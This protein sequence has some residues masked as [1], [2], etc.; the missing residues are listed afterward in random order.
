[1]NDSNMNSEVS[2]LHTEND[3]AE[4]EQATE[5]LQNESIVSEL[6]NVDD[7][8][9]TY[10]INESNSP[11][12]LKFELESLAIEKARLLKEHEKLNEMLKSI[13]LEEDIAL[14]KGEVSFLAEENDKILLEIQRRKQSTL[15]S[16]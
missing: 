16:A 3:M 15:K 11:D 1:M 6:W 12:D 7:D 8:L 5:P 4:T 14:L 13:K 9:T 10:P 2:A